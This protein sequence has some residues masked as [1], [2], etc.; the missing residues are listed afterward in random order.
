MDLPVVGGFAVVAL[1]IAFRLLTER[2]EIKDLRNDL[3]KCKSEL[4]VLKDRDEA[5]RTEKHRLAGELTN[6]NLRLGLVIGMAQRAAEHCTC[7]AAD[8]LRE[9]LSDPHVNPITPQ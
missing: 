7:H 3:D 4:A 9:F 1:V 2:G 8:T 6:A 5:N